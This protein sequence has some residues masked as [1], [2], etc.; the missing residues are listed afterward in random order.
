[1]FSLKHLESIRLAELDI[2]LKYF[3]KG[4]H[5]LEIGAGTGQQAKLLSDLNFTVSAI[6]IKS[7][8]YSQ[9][10]H[11]NVIEYDGSNFPFSENSFDVVFSSNVLEHISDLA[12][13]HNEIRRVLRDDGIAVH[14]IPSHYWRIWTIISSVPN[15]FQSITNS[16][17]ATL[18]CL[19][20]SSCN[21]SYV[22][23]AW[24][25]SLGD[26]KAMIWQR[27]HGER[28]NFLSEIFYFHPVWWNQ[29]FQANGFCLLKAAPMGIFYS[30]YMVMG[31][32]W[33]IPK[34]IKL[35]KF[36]GS[37]SY[38]YVLKARN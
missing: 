13:I 33:T 8:I 18:G 25:R 24:M 30:G 1:V 26:I 4:A 38:I 28:G 31:S 2:L 17:C 22:K 29:N 35:A 12:Q 34:R 32:Y 9:D 5:V 10:R 37:A 11:Y 27:R 20:R 23:N 16:L 15:G 19:F 36:L 7:S 3:P 14:V 21:T 6:E